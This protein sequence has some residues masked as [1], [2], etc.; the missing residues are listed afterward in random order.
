MVEKFDEAFPE[1]VLFLPVCV[2][3]CAD[4]H[5]KWRAIREQWVSSSH[6]AC[7]RLWLLQ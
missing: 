7:V 4:A 5:S 6:E 2:C 1:P 3:V